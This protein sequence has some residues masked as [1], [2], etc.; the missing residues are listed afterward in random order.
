MT[1]EQDPANEKPAV[2]L[3]Q[4]D[5]TASYVFRGKKFDL[6]GKYST[7]GDAIRDAE[8]QCRN[9]GWSG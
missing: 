8:R 9:M 5:H 3:N 1:F 7:L 2:T 4:S 6:P